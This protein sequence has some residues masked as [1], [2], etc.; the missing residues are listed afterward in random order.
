MFGSYM[1]L[2]Q[3]Y[4]EIDDRGS[5]GFHTYT[6]TT[7]ICSVHTYS[8]RTSDD[9]DVM[10]GLGLMVGGLWKGG[11]KPVTPPPH[12]V[13]MM[14]VVRARIG[15][16]GGRRRLQRSILIGAAGRGRWNDM[17]EERYHQR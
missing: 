4:L 16:G 12:E 9:G 8:Y 14:V 5:R 13:M 3:P 2:V 6:I 7:I 1:S 15:S 10:S 11:M 17:E